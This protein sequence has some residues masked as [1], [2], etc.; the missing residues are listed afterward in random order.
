MN[1]SPTVQKLLVGAVL[2]GAWSA[3]VFMGKV[4]PT[5]YVENIKILLGG[6]GL[7]HVTTG[8]ARA[9]QKAAADAVAQAASNAPAPTQV[10]NE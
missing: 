10:V 6:L 1:L 7:Y 4:A 9:A 8:P 3:L 5:D 2:F